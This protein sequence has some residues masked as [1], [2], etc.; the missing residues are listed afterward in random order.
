MAALSKQSIRRTGTNPSY[1]ACSA[2]GDS[3]VPS[4]RTFLHVKNASA[5][6]LT[7]TVVAT[8]VPATDMTVTNLSVAVP[9][10]GE[11]MIGPITAPEFVDAT[12][13][14]QI[15]YSGVTSLTIAALELSS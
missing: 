13:N 10:G 15:T 7:V 8:K 4:D 12:G 11:R 14:A 3:V 1:S 9:A 6:S 2:G 5:G